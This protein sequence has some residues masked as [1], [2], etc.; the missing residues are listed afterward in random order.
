MINPFIQTNLATNTAEQNLIHDLVA[1][2][3]QFNGI[4]FVYLPRT[5]NNDD[6][7]FHESTQSTFS[8]VFTIEGYLESVESFEGD[9]DMLSGL[10][11]SI[12]DQ[13]SIQFA[14]RR[15]R[16]VTGKYLPIEGDLLYYKNAKSIFEIKFVQNES[17]FYPMGTLPS[18]KMTCEKY[19]YSGETFTTGIP[20]LDALNNTVV[21]SVGDT[22][23]VPA[24]YND[25]NI[26]I[27]IE[28]DTV[29][30]FSE[31]NPFGQA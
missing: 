13:A 14:Q 24:N 27:Q 12:K 18:F 20:E 21:D 23:S 3:I 4:D 30:S 28:A 10:G 1:E 11:L 2:S 17:Q 8:Q 9:G 31:T 16:T 6:P 5:M 19:E 7:L 26:P 25:A 15:F 29:M 22:V